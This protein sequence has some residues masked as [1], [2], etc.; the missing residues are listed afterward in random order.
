MVGVLRVDRIDSESK[1]VEFKFQIRR[2]SFTMFRTS[3]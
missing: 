3:Q 2:K 1:N